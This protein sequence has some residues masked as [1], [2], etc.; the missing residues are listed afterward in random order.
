MSSP[1]PLML[2]MRIVCRCDGS[3]RDADSC[4]PNVSA[5]NID[6]GF[7]T[8]YTAVLTARASSAPFDRTCEGTICTG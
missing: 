2:F 8:A 6:N 1:E 7:G 5:V 3:A 4:S